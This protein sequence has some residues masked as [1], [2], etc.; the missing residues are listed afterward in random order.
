[1][2][3]L[4]RS[5]PVKLLAV[6]AAFAT[7]A[8]AQITVVSYLVGD[9]SEIGTM[10]DPVTSSAG[11]TAGDLFYSIPPAGTPTPQTPGYSSATD[12][13]YAN[14]VTLPSALQN[15]R[16]LAFTLTIADGYTMDLTSLSFNLGGTNTTADT[17]T[18]N[19]A[20][21][22]SIDSLNNVGNT[23]TSSFGNT[24][25]GAGSFTL[26]PKS[27]DLS[28]VGSLQGLSGTTTFYLHFWDSVD[29]QNM[30]M[31]INNIVLEG[32]VTSI[33]EPSSAAIGA[34]L[35]VVVAAGLRRRR[36]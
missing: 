3:T 2:N 11:I 6:L 15:N 14:A 18:V 28:S 31:R 17:Y 30:S 23:V 16:Y 29:T 9:Y 5:R 32:T 19:A 24:G 33:P 21:R 36:R 20:L 13:F 22:T 26:F 35:V 10:P 12:T 1:M 8:S 4:L 7:A 34:G 27:I 25:G